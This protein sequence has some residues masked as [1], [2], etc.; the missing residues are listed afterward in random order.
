MLK[1][2]RHRNVTE[3]GQLVCAK[4][5]RGDHEVTPDICQACPVAAIL[6]AQTVGAYKFN[7]LRLSGA[8]RQPATVPDQQ[9]AAQALAGAGAAPGD[10]VQTGV[11]QESCATC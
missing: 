10:D 11:G 8:L 5:V 7:N 1:P 3:Q 6:G 4:I 2:C 9:I